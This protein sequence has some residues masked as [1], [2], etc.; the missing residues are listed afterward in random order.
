MRITLFKIKKPKRFGFRPRYYDPQREDL[1]MRINRVKS[2]LEAVEK[3]ESREALRH[4][5]RHAWSSPQHRASM[6]RTS[7][8]RIMVIAGILL[9]ILYLLIFADFSFMS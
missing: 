6:N 3:S 4:R 9:L 5:M 1:E 7:N 2:E 8:I